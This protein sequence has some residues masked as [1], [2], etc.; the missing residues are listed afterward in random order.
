MRNSPTLFTSARCNIVDK[1]PRKCYNF[2][3]K[4]DEGDS[5]N[6]T[7]IVPVHISIVTA[8][9]KISSKLF[10]TKNATACKRHSNPGTRGLTDTTRS[11][12]LQQ[13]TCAIDRIVTNI[14]DNR[15]RANRLFHQGPTR[16]F[17]ALFVTS[18]AAN[19]ELLR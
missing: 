19:T 5:I 7:K 17:F 11:E 18:R 14:P 10:S 8:I 4:H 13:F 15:W 12:K 16:K 6:L 3:R 1:L 2:P 9:H